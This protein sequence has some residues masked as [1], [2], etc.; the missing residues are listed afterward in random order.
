MRWRA[1]ADDNMVLIIPDNTE[2]AETIRVFIDDKGRPGGREVLKF[3]DRLN[4]L[5][6][7]LQR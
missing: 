5:L 1:R 4:R 7:E 2:L 3:A 6:M